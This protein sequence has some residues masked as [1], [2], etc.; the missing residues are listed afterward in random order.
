[1]PRLGGAGKTTVVIDLASRL[2]ALSLGASLFLSRGY[3]GALNG[4]CGSIRSRYDARDVGDEALL[5]AETATVWLGAQGC[6]GAGCGRRWGG[7]SADG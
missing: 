2:G 3:G 6:H 5:L 1:M 7:G 4:R